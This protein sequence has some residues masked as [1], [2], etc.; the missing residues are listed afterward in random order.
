MKRV[1]VVFLLLV[2]AGG[3]LFAQTWGWSGAF[4]SGL[5][6]FK[7]DG[8]DDPAFGLYS[9]DLGIDGMRAQLQANYTNADGNAGARLRLRAQGTPENWPNSQAANVLGFRAAFG[10]FTLADGFVKIL[11]GRIQDYEFNMV[12]SIWGDTF[13]D[14]WGVQSY[15]YP[16]DMVKFG[17]GVKTS[18]RLTEGKIFDDGHMAGWLGLGVG[19]GDF[20]LTAQLQAQKD[21]TRAFVSFAYSGLDILSFDALARVYDLTNFGDSGAIGLNET[22]SLNLVE[23][24]GLDIT[25]YQEFSN[26]EADEKPLIAF[27]VDVYYAIGQICPG[28]SVDYAMGGE[29]DGRI[30]WDTTYADH[31]YLG[32]SPYLQVKVKGD[33][34]AYIQLG[35]YLAKDMSNDTPSVGKKGGTNHAAYLSFVYTF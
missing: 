22:V 18:A 9:P 11:G 21:N 13:Y 17:V 35:Y 2:L 25:A 30:G 14:S 29:H 16:S 1:L 31:S 24:L 7:L 20:D 12:D 4:Y 33:Y 10:W 6:M 27:N 34:N 28:L 5:G 32:V 15:F 23:N 26:A 8:Q 19:A 3:G